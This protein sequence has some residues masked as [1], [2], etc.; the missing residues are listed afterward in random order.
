MFPPIIANILSFH[1]V[2]EHNHLEMVIVSQDHKRLTLLL[3]FVCVIHA[4]ND[5]C[6]NKS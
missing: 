4:N 2:T 6:G 1:R 3:Y 5:Y